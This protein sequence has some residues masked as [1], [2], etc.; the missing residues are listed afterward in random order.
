[1]ST[2]GSY[3]FRRGSTWYVKLRNP[4][5]RIEKSLHTS[6]RLEAQIAAAP[7]IDAHRAALLAAKPR[8]E[9]AH[10]REYEPGLHTGLDGEKIYATA[11]ELHYLDESP[12]RIES[13]GAV[14]R[15]LIARGPQSALTEFSMLDEAYGDAVQPKPPVRTGDDEIVETYC[16]HNNLS[17]HFRREANAVWAIYKRL[18]NDKPLKDA[19]RDDGRLLVK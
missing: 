10:E 7:L 3:L 5:G 11:T 17:E 19:T 12:I 18:T 1:M 4:L 16:T 8:I 2:Y 14:G 9:I 15:R 6:N 13:N